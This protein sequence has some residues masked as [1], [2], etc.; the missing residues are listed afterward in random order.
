MKI[1]LLLI[2]LGLCACTSV[3]AQSP[4]TTPKAC[5]KAEVSEAQ[6]GFLVDEEALELALR[7]LAVELKA[8][9]AQQPTKQMQLLRYQML[10]NLLRKRAV[11]PQVQETPKQ[12]PIVININKS[13]LKEKQVV[14]EPKHY[15]KEQPVDTTTLL[16]KKRLAYLEARLKALELKEAKEVKAKQQIVIHQNEAKQVQEEHTKNIRLD[17]LKQRLLILNNQNEK[18]E[19]LEQTLAEPN[20]DSLTLKEVE[21]ALT[22]DTLRLIDTIRLVDTVE[23]VEKFVNVEQVQVATDFH[24]E[25]FFALNS[26]KLTDKAKLLLDEA[27]RF[28]TDYPQARLLISGSASVD[29]SEEAN[30]RLARRRQASVRA[31]L[32]AQGIAPNR[33]DE[34]TPC[35]DT[36]V[37]T[38]AL[39]RRVEIKLIK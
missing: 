14:K 28:M 39:A 35:I 6:E 30:L 38:G 4:K 36:D 25:V 9:K 26:A 19:K 1:K 8:K 13:E 2:G 34:T 23:L 37:I 16:L 18:L 27:V 22:T 29:G 20:L 21:Q 32:E 5:V 15:A 3:W 7:K 10:I 33:F 11:V 31:Y 12:A 24:R 17:S